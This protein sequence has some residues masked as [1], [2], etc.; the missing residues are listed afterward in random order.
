M[1]A[2][3]TKQNK[4]VTIFFYPNWLLFR[5]LHSANQWTNQHHFY[6]RLITEN[7]PLLIP[8]KSDTKLSFHRDN[9]KI[10]WK[11]AYTKIEVDFEL[12]KIVQD[13]SDDF[14]ELKDKFLED[15][16]RRES[17][18]NNIPYI[19]GKTEK[20]KR[21]VP[22]TYEYHP[23]CP[24]L[25]VNKENS[26]FIFK[27][28][29]DDKDY[30][31]IMPAF[32]L[33][34]SEERAFWSNLMTLTEYLIDILSL[35]GGLGIFLKVGRFAM[36]VST[37]DSILLQGIKKG[38]NYGGASIFITSGVGR[39][40]LKLTETRDTPLGRAISEVLFY[41]EMTAIVGYVGVGV[42]AFIQRSAQ[43]ALKYT[44]DIEK[45]YR[46]V[47]ELT[48]KNT[49]KFDNVT[50]TDELVAAEERLAAIWKLEEIAGG[51]TAN[52]LR[53]LER[54]ILKKL[55]IINKSEVINYEYFLE[56]S[57]I[58]KRTFNVDLNVVSKVSFEYSELFK[59]WQSDPIFAVFHH[60]KFVNTRYQI[61][62][63]GPAIYFF[64]G[65]STR[66]GQ[67]IEITTYTVQHELFHLKLWYKFER[68][69]GKQIP[70]RIHEEYVLSEFV[71]SSE[72][73]HFDDLMNDLDILNLKYRATEGLKSVDLNYFKTWNL[74]SELKKIK[75]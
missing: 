17:E 68:L 24:I 75:F 51:E 48:K 5:L 4:K 61:K 11:N 60:K 59:K 3:T 18:M 66:L 46:E 44:D 52:I 15:Y 54:D 37:G 26:K 74:E 16:D 13:L 72:K 10:Y 21:N 8:Y 36:A 25:I 58:V 70:R 65:H 43:K 32:V 22:E 29:G 56:I 6:K 55:N 53:E 69:T 49:D 20:E 41:L 27:G 35:A 42:H 9:A 23:F 34:A 2:R 73:W 63:D 31:T 14:E 19:E 33:L 64:S 38:V 67:S 47:D 1:F 12:P 50:K 7:N 57:A 30:A 40:L 39:G 28:G 45:I 71:K 62:L